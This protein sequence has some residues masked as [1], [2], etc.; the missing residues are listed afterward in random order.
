MKNIL[1]INWGRKSAGTVIAYYFIKAL[2]KK[3]NLWHSISKNSDYFYETNLINNKHTNIYTYKN[4]LSFIFNSIFFILFS[5]RKILKF[6]KIKKI[7]I[8]LFPMFHIWNSLI[9]KDL[10]KLNIKVILCNHDAN[11]HPG[12]NSILINYL[13]KYIIN[14]TE[15]HIVFSNHVRKQLLKIIGNENK[16]T[17]LTLPQLININYINKNKS[18]KNDHLS[19][20]FFGRLLK[21]KGIDLLLDAIIEI[22]NKISINLTLAGDGKISIYQKK[23]NK[24]KNIKILNKWLNDSEI[25]DLFDKND[26]CIL[27]YIEASQSGI[28]PVSFMT[29]TPIIATN[30]GGLSE[31][32]TNDHNGLLVEKNV[33]DLSKAILK[34]YN[35]N[36]FYK[37]LSKG[38]L[39]TFEENYSFTAFS[40]Q[41]NKYVS[42]IEL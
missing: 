8:V 24:I 12:E 15:H 7:N 20:I 6:I 34:I 10:K 2:K 9:I 29:G 1:I 42:N 30:T 27:P 41:I 33:N 31:Q 14:K 40:K 26:L 17:N 4:K 22:Q 11:L 25:I 32:I 35:N 38:S 5:R 13:L 19:I 39:N 16:I 36:E 28:V 21:Y 23:I 3:N 18:L 37:N